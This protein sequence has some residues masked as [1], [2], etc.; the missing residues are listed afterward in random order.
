MAGLINQLI[1]TLKKQ[2]EI[3]LQLLDSA[4]EKKQIIIKN[5]IEEL[6]AITDQENILVGK[7]LRLDKE[8]IQYF[9]D[10]AFVLNKNKD[11]MTLSYLVELI[12]GQAEYEELLQLKND[13]FGIL[14]KLKKIN[15]QNEDLINYSLEY[16]EYSMNLIRS[17][18]NNRPYYCDSRGQEISYGGEGL[19]DTKQ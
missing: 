8:R 7:S 13:I 1:D 11:D 15:Q 10:I 3:Y 2:K 18:L 4:F 6:Q 9:E 16:V 19:F 14:E 17:A 12:E 5:N